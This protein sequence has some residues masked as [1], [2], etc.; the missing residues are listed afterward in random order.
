VHGYAQLSL[1]DLRRQHA[2]PEGDGSVS[3][4]WGL[5]ATEREGD[6]RGLSLLY[7]GASCHFPG[8]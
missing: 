3:S 5:C 6:Y 8:S 4:E 7:E 2:S 1:L